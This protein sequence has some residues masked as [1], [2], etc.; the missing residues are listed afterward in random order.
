MVCKLVERGLLPSGGDSPKILGPKQE[1]EEQILQAI[2]GLSYG[3][4]EVTVHAGK[5]VQIERKEKV[6]LDKPPQ[7]E[8]QSTKSRPGAVHGTGKRQP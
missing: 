7:T 8:T 3:S 4:V 1:L 6:R 2:R 5:V